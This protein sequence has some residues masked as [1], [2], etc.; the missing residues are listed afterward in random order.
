MPFEKGCEELERRR[1]YRLFLCVLLICAVTA[2]FICWLLFVWERVPGMIHIR[3]GVQQE[4][5]LAQVSPPGDGNGTD[6]RCERAET[7]P[8]R[9]P[10]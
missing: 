8:V 5:E 2:L 7:E 4:L 9:R 6:R 3:A 1:K 10:G